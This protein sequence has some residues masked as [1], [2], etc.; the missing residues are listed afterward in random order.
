MV[1]IHNVSSEESEN[2][3]IEINSYEDIPNFNNEEEEANFWENHC[4]GDKILDQMENFEN[5]PLT[6]NE[7]LG[8]LRKLPKEKQQEVLDFTEF[9]LQKVR[10]PLL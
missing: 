10:S 5:I 9:L 6:E 4:L 8:K 2:S 7:I 1:N 3:M